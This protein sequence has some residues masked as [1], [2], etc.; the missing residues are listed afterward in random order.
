[1]NLKISNFRVDLANWPKRLPFGVRVGLSAALLAGLALLTFII[2]SAAIVFDNMIEEADFVLAERSKALLQQFRFNPPSPGDLEAEEHSVPLNAEMSA[3]KLI[4]YSSPEIEWFTRD[5]RWK[6]KSWR[7]EGWGSRRKH[8][9]WSWN[10]LD[11]WR[12]YRAQAG[13]E[14]RILLAMDL[15]EIRREVWRMCKTFLTALPITLIIIAFGGWWMARRSTVP[16]QHLATA[17]EHVAEG[18]LTERV[19][20]SHARDLLDRL[21]RVF[22]RMTGR[23]QTSFEQAT[24]FSSDASHELRT[25]LTILRGQLENALQKAQGEQAVQLAELL[26]QT[27]RLRG[28]IHGLLLLSRSDA[29]KLAIGRDEVDFS[30]IVS[31][32]AGDFESALGEAGIALETRIAPNLRVQGDAGLLRQAV[33]NLLSNAEKFNLSRD[34]RIS[35]KL[36]RGEGEIRLCVEN[37]GEPIPSHDAKRV[38]RRFYRT[39]STRETPSAPGTGLGLSI[40]EAVTEAHGGRAW[41]EPQT[42]SN[43]FNLAFPDREAAD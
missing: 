23:L 28:I 4:R 19:E 20:L 9:V 8:T 27:E 26:A 25:P 16:L 41:C 42:A 3:V 32:V 22:N 34:G 5:Q 43:C 13:E 21:A 17:M 1:M 29:G 11:V 35:V 33:V 15:S 10:G 36:A 30:E 24:R 2:A 38:F 40:V 31:E 7:K 14:R 18:D 12:T 37:A 39:S 6:Q